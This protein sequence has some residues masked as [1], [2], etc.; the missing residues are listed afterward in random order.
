MFNSGPRPDLFRAI[1][2]LI[3]GVS[4]V[5]DIKPG[6]FP[7]NINPKS[8]GVIAVA[9]LTTE[10]FDAATL[11]PITVRFGRNGVEAAPV[12]LALTDIDKDGTTDV[13]LH[14]RIPAT[15][16]QCG[17]ISAAITGE[18]FGGQLIEGFDSINTVGCKSKG[19]K[20]LIATVEPR[21]K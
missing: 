5:V 15:G 8:K 6:N 3:T 14:F 21:S 10:T 9:L 18:A 4:V 17:D 20:P 19:Q 12:R 7:N 16:I 1:S 13:I 11:D 2:Q